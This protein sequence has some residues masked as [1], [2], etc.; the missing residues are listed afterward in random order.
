[1]SEAEY[2]EGI[3]TKKLSSQVRERIRDSALLSNTLSNLLAF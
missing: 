3:I 1:M 2:I